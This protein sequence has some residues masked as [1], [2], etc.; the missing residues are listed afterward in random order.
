MMPKAMDLRTAVLDGTTLIE[1]SAGT[2]KT[3][4][5][6]GLFLRLVLEKR[7]TVDQ[8]LV[9]TFTDAATEELRG[10]IRE[11]LV[12]ILAVLESDQPPS[13]PKKTFERHLW[14][15]HR[16][17]AG[18][19]ILREAIRNFDLAQIYTI[20]GFCQ[21]MLGKNGFESQTLFTTTLEPDLTDLVRQACVDFWRARIMPIEG[22]PGKRIRSVVTPENL[23]KLATLPFLAQ[24]V[25]MAPDGPVPDVRALEDSFNQARDRFLVQWPA[26]RDDVRRLLLEYPG[27]KANMRKP[28]LIERRLEAVDAWVQ[29]PESDLP[30]ELQYFTPGHMEKMRTK[31]VQPPEHEMF[32][33][34]RELKEAGD[35]L[36]ESLNLACACLRRDFLAGLSGD[37]DARKRVRN[38]QG[39]DDLLRSMRKAV[40]SEGMRQAVRAQFKAALIDEF[41]DTD[42]LQYDIFGRL[43]HEERC[44]FLIGDPKQAIYS[45][46]GAD[47]HTYLHASRQCG[48]TT[49][50]GVNYRSTPGLIRAVNRIF[51]A[52]DDPFRNREIAFRPVAPS[53]LD[54]AQ[55]T[56][57]GLA[58][59]PMTIWQPRSGEG[60]K[61]L[62]KSKLTP[63]ICGCVA[64]EISRLLRGAAVGRVKLGNRELRPGDIAI[65]VEKHRQGAL[66]HN[67]LRELGIHSVLA[68]SSSVFESPEAREI[69]TVL[70][71]LAEYKRPKKMRAALTTHVIG[72]DAKDLRALD[73][74][75][76]AQEAWLE[77]LAQWH[78]A[79]MKN[80]VMAAMSRLLTETGTRARLLALPSGERR[81]TNILHCL[82]ILHRQERESHASMHILLSWFA[83]QVA[84][85]RREEHQ[86]RLD[87]DRDA[88]RIVTIHKSKGLEYPVLFCPFLFNAARTEK[89][90]ALAHE[91][92]LVL[93]LGS[94]EL[95]VRKK[96]ALSEA[97]AELVRLTYV[98]MTRASS[99]CYMV[100]GRFNRSETSG[101]AWLF[102]GTRADSEG[103][104]KWKDV[105]D[106]DIRDDLEALSCE[107]IQVEDL[108]ELPGEFLDHRA[109]VAESLAP[110]T[111]TRILETDFSL[112]S[113]TGLTRG[114]EHG[115]RPGLDED[116]AAGV[117]GDDEWSMARFP[118]GAAA[119]SCLHHVFERIDFTDPATVPGEVADA[120][121]AYGFDAAWER[122]VT[123]MILRTL[124][125]D[126]GGFRLEQ[127][128]PKDRLTEL[129]FLFPLRPVTREGLAAVYREAAA[130]LPATL[131]ERMESLRFEPR[132]GFM[133]GF[134]DLVVRHEKKFYLL[135]WKSNWLGPTPGHYTP[136]ALHA[137]M[138]GSH[139]FMQYHLY[140][141]ALKR[142]L[143]LRNPKFDY[144]EHFGGVRYVF[145]RGVDPEQQGQG[146][147]KDC[148]DPRFLDA[149]DKALIDM[150]NR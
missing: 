72:L 30:E 38:I 111:W 8:V 142:H 101:P 83:R 25:R 12:E 61:P 79:W 31:N 2:G 99:R 94:P 73:A 65:L 120:L 14:Q 77:R 147:H 67:A 63:R 117:A 139:Y 149:L 95:E 89:D 91:G 62:S 107:D 109:S 96:A 92:G 144:A 132:R 26:H 55:L 98:A 104:I 103:R 76:P 116:D 49:T 57:D 126:M 124:R 85:N 53:D 45:F 47:L 32:P 138:A 20:H 118:R 4:T 28:E 148:P 130:L 44:L 127:I 131:P 13:D 35:A 11:R 64:A 6:A 58:Q 51:E 1:A 27:L 60:T 40:D 69:L 112:A 82:E 137:A 119:G 36:Q 43:F 52:S 59:P 29:R 86:L 87:S 88:V 39:F 110:R 7:L 150:E 48:R 133:T 90:R 37:M 100:W 146:V 18:L 19:Q 56:E 141:L 121:A 102:H 84:S 113:F 140:C 93:D 50:L 122:T 41:Q 78:S 68:H 15:G 16:D 129:E 145:L 97:Q 22:L 24:D 42:G 75:G 105:S 106:A 33:V 115:L 9:V 71:A 54:I 81:M 125:T 80:G 108:P 143:A 134:M 17:A 114:S 21:K 5:L 123:D 34:A 70:H 136:D 23:Q 74:D 135:D 128:G 3:Y 10:R 46:R 66:M